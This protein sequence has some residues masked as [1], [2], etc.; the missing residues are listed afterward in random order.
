MAHTVV[1]ADAEHDNIPP[2]PLALAWSC[3]LLLLQLQIVLS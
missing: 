1:S 3:L 2:T